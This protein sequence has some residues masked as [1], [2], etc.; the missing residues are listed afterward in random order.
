MTFIYRLTVYDHT[1]RGGPMHLPASTPIIA[2]DNFRLHAAAQRAFHA[3]AEKNNVPEWSKPL[4]RV[5][6]IGQTYDFGSFGMRIT[7][8]RLR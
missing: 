6:A 7:K 3:I 5:P 2:T 1:Q 8:E 4:P